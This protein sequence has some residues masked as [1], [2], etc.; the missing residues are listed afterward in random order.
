M[1]R[2]VGSTVSCSM[3]SGDAVAFGDAAPVGRAGPAQ[4]VHADFQAGA[5]DGVHIQHVPRS[6]TYAET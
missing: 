3:V 1:K 2:K 6:F 4:R 5:A